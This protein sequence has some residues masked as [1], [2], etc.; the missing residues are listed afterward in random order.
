LFLILYIIGIIVNNLKKIVYY[1]LIENINGA[2]ND[3][4]KKINAINSSLL[5]FYNIS[6]NKLFSDSILNI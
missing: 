6:V 1:F 5:K 3:L 2:V 4:T